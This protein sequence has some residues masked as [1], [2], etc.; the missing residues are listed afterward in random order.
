M[1]HAIKSMGNPFLNTAKELVVL[2]THDC[3]DGEVVEALYRMEQLGKEQ[4]SRYVSDVLVRREESIHS[5][6]KRNNLP[7]FK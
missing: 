1:C 2:D 4:Y 6:I 5:T 3:M 7:L